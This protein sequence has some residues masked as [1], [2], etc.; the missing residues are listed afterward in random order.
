MSY[1]NHTGFCCHRGREPRRLRV[2][3][4]I[5]P[6]GIWI[7]RKE[8]NARGVR[9]ANSFYFSFASLVF[10]APKS[11]KTWPNLALQKVTVTLFNPP[12][13]VSRNLFSI[14]SQ[15]L[16][17]Y[18]VLGGLKTVHQC[19]QTTTNQ[20]EDNKAQTPQGR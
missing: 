6:P 14:H 2:S 17:Y 5:S 7:A 18:M 20:T 3:V 16:I 19:A 11:I 8:F 15:D 1:F 12:N 13:C 4:S 10:I 9:D